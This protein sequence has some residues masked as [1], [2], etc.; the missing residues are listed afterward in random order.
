[1]KLHCHKE[2]KKTPTGVHANTFD[3][4][5]FPLNPTRPCLCTATAPSERAVVI[6][7]TRE[8]LLTFAKG[9]LITDADQLST[10][11]KRATLDETLTAVDGG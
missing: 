11:F 5:L 6:R 8:I 1:M 3:L 9:R 4:L 10:D 2:E 7:G